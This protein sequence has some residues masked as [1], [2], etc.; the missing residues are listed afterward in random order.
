MGYL[1][2]TGDVS[3]SGYRRAAVMGSVMGSFA[4]ESFSADRLLALDR[5]AVAQRLSAFTD[6]ASFA[7]IDTD[8]SFP[9]RDDPTP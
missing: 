9:W 5:G 8:G 6:L 7:A 4:V 2:A 3:E 1:C